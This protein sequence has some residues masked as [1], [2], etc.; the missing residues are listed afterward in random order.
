M[1]VGGGGGSRGIPLLGGRL[2]E[3][4]GRVCRF[5]LAGRGSDPVGIST[6]DVESLSKN[7][8]SERDYLTLI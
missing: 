2:W 6:V 5:E 3:L 7:L 4:M 1:K 8:E